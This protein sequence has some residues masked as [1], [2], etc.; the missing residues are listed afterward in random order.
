MN[1]L[2]NIIIFFAIFTTSVM[3]GANRVNVRLIED[4]P[5]SEATDILEDKRGYVWIATANGLYRYDGYTYRTYQIGVEGNSLNSN[6][7]QSISEDSYGNIWVGTYGQ[8]VSK[9]DVQNDRVTNYSLS[10]IYSQSSK[11]SE[12]NTIGVDRNDNIWVGCQGEVVKLTINKESYDIERRDLYTVS[13]SGSYITKIHTDGLG[14]MWIGC[15]DALKRVVG[16]REGELIFEEYPYHCYDICN[17]DESSIVIASQEIVT[18]TR[19]GSVYASK[20]L[21]RLTGEVAYDIA[22]VGEREIWFGGRRGINCISPNQREEWEI[23]EHYDKSNLPFEASTNIVSSMFVSQTKQLWVATRGGVWSVRE[24]FKPFNNYPHLRSTGAIPR[25][26]VKSLV[27]DSNQNLWVGTEDSGVYVLQGDAI[28]KNITINERDNRACAMLQTGDGVS[29]RSVMWVGKGSFP[30]L[31]A[32]DINTLQVIPQRVKLPYVSLVLS[33]AKS[34]DNT[35]WVGTYNSGL[36][37]LN[38]NNRGEIVDIKQFTTLNSS[39]ESDIVRSLYLS[40]EGELWIGTNIG[41]N[42]L[43]REDISSEDPMFLRSLSDTGEHS[44][45]NRYINQIIETKGGDMLFGTIGH[46]LLCYDIESDSIRS[47]TTLDGLADNAIKSILEDPTADDIWLATNRGLSK[48]SLSSGAIVNY[49]ESDGL[50]DCEFTEACGIRRMDGEMVFGNRVGYLSFQ[51]Q[52]I[53]KS[54]DTPKLYFTDLYINHN[55]VEIG[56]NSILDRALEYTSRIDLKYDERNFSIGFVGLN[57]SSAYENIYQ[58]KLEG[59]DGSW[60]EI[61]DRDYIAQYTNVPEGEYTFKVRVANGDEVWSDRVLSLE[62]KISPP[63]YRSNIAY[64][65]YI[66]LLALIVYTIYL[67]LHRKQQLFI[68]QVERQKMEE[69]TK[70]KLEFFMNVSHEFRTPLTL[71]NIPLERVLKHVDNA[72]LATDLAEMK[73]NVDQLMTLINQLL[74]FGRIESVNEQINPQHIDVVKYVGSLCNHFKLLAETQHVSYQFSSAERRVFAQIDIDLFGKVIINLLSNAFKHTPANS[75]IKISIDPNIDKN[76]VVISIYNSGCGVSADEIPHLFERYYQARNNQAIGSGIGLSLCKSI[77]ELHG[78][79]IRFESELNS[80]FVCYIEL[81]IS[82]QD[83]MPESSTPQKEDVACE[84]TPHKNRAT[85]LIVEDNETLRAQLCRELQGEYNIIT[86]KDGEEGIAKCIKYLP[87]LVITDIVM[88]KMGGIEMCRQIKANEMVSHTPILVL[89]ANST[90][91]NQI[92]SFTIGGADGYLEKPFNMEIFR[93]KISTI[94]K[95]REIVKSQFKKQSIVDPEQI[96]S[97]PADLKCLKMV[98]KIIKANIGNADLSVEQ[99]ASEYGVSRIYLNQKIKAITGETSS[100]FLRSIRLKYAAKLLLQKQMS[101]SEVA[102]VVGYNDVATF[103]N[104]FKKM[105]GVLP[106]HYAGEEAISSS[107]SFDE[108]E[109]EQ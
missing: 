60:R 93:G 29:N 99:I 21:M 28:I 40:V 106:T 105:F 39:L 88:P 54:T 68:A 17:Y 85:L 89:T 75:G 44:L 32:V 14:C 92:D 16:Q 96:A 84:I 61:R 53:K 43:K 94:L 47:I 37:R 3:L 76:G 24:N 80:Y 30:I 20:I 83:S 102:C 82:S 63:F 55:R 57:F 91:K 1:I 51:P 73:Y 65:I 59:L 109:G 70:Y 25:G 78:G 45:L 98:I 5:Y 95:N 41:V 11:F 74:D 50:Q 12:I 66:L 35:L 38:I 81:P 23:T 19:S 103:R 79:T 31:A 56:G 34:D 2:K 104:R 69:I 26:I 36:W 4:I 8:N 86:A 90:V 72:E 71:I 58:I 46:G 27:E 13:D 67:L 33:L 7:I 64:I 48:Y 6:M 42:R 62:I 101:V 77:I 10:D 107:Y 9:I 100:Q 97:S 22:C 49:G 18:L 108:P 87:S 15:N 52:Q